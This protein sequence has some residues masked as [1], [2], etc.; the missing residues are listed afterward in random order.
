LESSNGDFQF[1]DYD[2]DPKGLIT[3]LKGLNIKITNLSFPPSSAKTSYSAEGALAQ[4]A[5][6]PPARIKLSGTTYFS[7]LGTE[8]SFAMTG[9][10]LPYFS[11]YYGQVLDAV[12]QEGYLDSR[13]S[14]KIENKL[15]VS[16]ADLEISQLAFQ[17]YESDN[18]LFG[19]KADD[20]LSFLRDS[21]NR[22]KLQI[23]VEWNMQDRSVTLK[24]VI[25]RSIEKSLKKT[26]LGNVGNIIANT[27]QKLGN[28][29]LSQTK[30]GIEGKLKKIKALLNY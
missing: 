3:A 11:A 26:V 18:Q 17:S 2:A 24:R 13:A 4:G 27:I 14:L 28:G 20:I 25:R 22:L 7:T 16:D 15:L 10:H 6:V 1:I 19:L 29:T 30:D 8:A 21:S 12:I 5:G 23:S 9:V